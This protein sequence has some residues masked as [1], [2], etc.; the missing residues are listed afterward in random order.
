MASLFLMLTQSCQQIDT[1]AY[2][3]DE[4]AAIYAP[5]DHPVFQLVPPLFDDL[6]NQHYADIGQPTITSDNFWDIYRDV[7][8]CFRRSAD[9]ELTAVLANSDRQETAAQDDGLPVLP[10]MRP[11]RNGEPVAGNLAGKRSHYVGGLTASGSTQT[12]ITEE[13]EYA[14]FT[15]SDDSGSGNDE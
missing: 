5:P 8:E 4:M 2:L 12:T 13:P 3:F 10:E 6:A 7:L 9:E 1:P 15:S 14:D 11:F